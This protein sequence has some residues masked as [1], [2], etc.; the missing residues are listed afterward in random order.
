MEEKEDYFIWE[1]YDHEN[2][3]LFYEHDLEYIENQ[4]KRE[5]TNVHKTPRNL[6]D[7][8]P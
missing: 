5:K 8:Q 1:E 3:K 7:I 2:N 6:R 4:P